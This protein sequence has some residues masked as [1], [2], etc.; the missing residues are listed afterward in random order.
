VYFHPLAQEA[1][2]QH[3]AQDASKGPAVYRFEDTAGRFEV[4]MGELREAGIVLLKMELALSD[5]TGST[6]FATDLFWFL[7]PK[8]SKPVAMAAGAGELVDD[9]VVERGRVASMQAW[10]RAGP[11]G[12]YVASEKD[13]GPAKSKEAKPSQAQPGVVD[14][15]VG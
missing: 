1:A 13:S 15:R 3:Y 8:A 11:I 10:E 14:P 2:S 4:Q 6:R 7:A 9:A 12:S 5:G